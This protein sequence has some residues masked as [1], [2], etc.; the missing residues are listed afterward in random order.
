MRVSASLWLQ[1]CRSERSHGLM[2]N[3]ILWSVVRISILP[4]VVSESFWLQNE[5]KLFLVFCISKILLPVSCW[6]V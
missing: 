3:T 4:I 6:D 5:K 1:G 2:D